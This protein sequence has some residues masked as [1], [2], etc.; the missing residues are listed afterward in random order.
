MAINEVEKIFL[1]YP[2]LPTLP[3]LIRLIPTATRAEAV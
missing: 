2:T 1:E 3:T